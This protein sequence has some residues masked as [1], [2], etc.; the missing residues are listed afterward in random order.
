MEMHGWKAW[1]EAW[2]GGMDGR[3]GWEAW[4]GG[5]DGRHGWEA[6]M[7]GM[8]GRHGWETWMGG[9]DGRHGWEAWMGGMDGR[10]G[11]ET[12]GGEARSS[13][14]GHLLCPHAFPAIPITNMPSSLPALL[15]FRGSIPSLYLSVSPRLS[16]PNFLPP[17]PPLSF[18]RIST[19]LLS[20]FPHLLTQVR[21]SDTSLLPF[22]RMAQRDVWLHQFPPSSCSPPPTPPASTPPPRAPRFLLLPWPQFNTQG[23]ESAAAA[24]AAA[25]GTESSGAAGAGGR[26]AEEEEVASGVVAVAAALAVGLATGR[27]V[28]PVDQGSALLG[29]QGARQG[30]ESNAAELCEGAGKASFHCLFFPLT[31][32]AC[33]SSALHHAASTNPNRPSAAATLEQELLSDD[34]IVWL[35]PEFVTAAAGDAAAAYAAQAGGGEAARSRERAPGGVGGARNGTWMWG[36]LPRLVGMS[37]GKLV[38][39][40]LAQRIAK[41]KGWDRP[42]AQ[43]V[44][45]VSNADASLKHR[46]LLAQLLRFVLRWPSLHTCHLANTARHHAL[47]DH[48][49]LQLASSYSALLSL[50][51]TDPPAHAAADAAAGAAAAAAGG[52]AAEGGADSG[53]GGEA[54]AVGD[55]T[56]MRKAGGGADEG[57]GRG[58]DEW[59]EEYE[60][61]WQPAKESSAAHAAAAARALSEQPLLEGLPPKELYAMRSFSLSPASS[62]HSSLWAWDDAGGP[63]PYVP[64]PIASVHVGKASE[65]G[66]DE[67]PGGEG[68]AAGWLVQVQQQRL[69]VPNLKTLW[70]SIPGEC[71][72]V[73]SLPRGWTCMAP[74]TPSNP[75]VPTTTEPAVA[76]SAGAAAAAQTVASLLIAGRCDV[77]V[78]GGVAAGQQQQQQLV[79]QADL[80]VCLVFSLSPNSPLI[81]SPLLPFSPMPPFSLPPHAPSSL[82]FPS[83][84]SPPPL[85]PSQALSPSPPPTVGAGDLMTAASGAAISG[86]GSEWSSYQRTWQRVEQ[87]SADSEQVTSLQQR[88]EQLSA[89]VAAS[90]RTA[91]QA[92]G[93]LVTAVAAVAALRDDAGIKAE[94]IRTLEE[95]LRA[96]LSGRAALRDDAGIKADRIRSLEEELRAALEAVQ[97]LRGAVQH[98]ET[99]IELAAAEAAACRAEVRAAEERAAGVERE[100]RMLVDRWTHLKLH[101]ADTLNEA[102]QL[103]EDLV[104]RTRASS[105]ALQ[106]LASQQPLGILQLAEPGVS[107]RLVSTHAPSRAL[108][109]HRC[110]DSACCSLAMSAAGH[111]VITGGEDGAVKVWDA[112]R[113]ALLDTARGC[114]GAVMDLAVL[115]S[116]GGGGGG[117]G[118]D[119]RRRSSGGGSNGAD[120]A[121]S[122]PHGFSAL[123]AA[124]SDHKLYLWDAAT[125]QLRH[126]L[127]GH[128][129][130]VVAVD[131]DEHRGGGTGTTGGGGIASSSSTSSSA[132]AI[133]AAYDR[134]MKL[135]DLERGFATVTLLCH[136]NCNA[137]RFAP[138]GLSAICSGHADG[139]LRMWDVRSGKL[140]N[141]VAAHAA[142]ITSLA[143]SSSAVSARHSGGGASAASIYDLVTCGRDNILRVFDL[144]SLAAKQVLRGPHGFRVA[145][146]WSRACVSPT[147][148]Y[149]AAGSMDGSVVVWSRRTAAVERH[150][151]PAPALAS[152]AGSG[153]GSGG[154]AGLAS[155][156]A[157]AAVAPILTSV[158]GSCGLPLVTGDRAGVVTTWE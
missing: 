83:P 35:P 18:P 17:R 65:W 22:T 106:H 29:E 4:M 53:P 48:V 38:L 129:D 6:W 91:A 152:G 19:P 8:D 131:V 97:E 87:L 127:T 13:A 137:L 146:N 103:Y 58:E 72:L 21:G 74:P 85:P 51:E 9:M 82:C 107:P 92:S 111:R 40:H 34:P 45:N 119:G 79:G 56:G 36:Y 130:K 105:R 5:M 148:E 136:S 108:R 134:S 44:A 23:E 89:D 47:G 60:S 64:R 98:K 100:N 30:S 158:W 99:A 155:G 31:S 66:K 115:G 124:C 67:G 116:E 113:S 81:P 24:E 126:T 57:W 61:P 14:P 59:S 120:S 27:I 117:G 39:A 123:L 114:L 139:H 122:L 147:D 94:R 95:E 110:H 2:M 12:W 55:A 25:T 32:A 140:A 86:R 10:H 121:P 84:S 77:H 102:N 68:V 118:A 138:G 156:A 7:G 96:A 63:E 154:S 132:R 78:D 37:R 62:L 75:A 3:H 151:R 69:R 33:R 109:S 112:H 135:W 16:H 49:S 52:A 104:E 153:A 50:P 20:P 149:V 28:V 76:A 15:P 11:W 26:V 143:L 133:S 125:W 46:W 71:Q 142:A 150:L 144:R 54:A 88:V 128:T 93:E 41:A 141:E 80:D 90:G 43:G 1:G 157:A 73:A 101:Q 42:W 70:M 145:S